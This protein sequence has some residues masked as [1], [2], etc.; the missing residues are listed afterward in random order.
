[1]PARDDHRA[2]ESGVELAGEPQW[3]K[4]SFVVGLKHLPTR[5]RIARG[6]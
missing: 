3:I 2:P 5:Y 6:A 4:S 1:V